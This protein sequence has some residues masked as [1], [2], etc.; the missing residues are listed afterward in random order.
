MEG[1][2]VLAV[3]TRVYPVGRGSFYDS[4]A[5][6]YMAFRT[7]KGKLE[8]NDKLFKVMLSSV[9]LEPK[10]RAYSNATIARFYKAEAQKEAMQDQIWA[11]LENKITETILGETANAERGSE[12]SA[13]GA[14]QNIRGVQTFRDPAT[15]GTMELSNL[16]DHAWL[17]GSNE[18]IMSNDPNFNPNTNLSGSWNQLQ[19]VRPAP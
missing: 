13:F 15:G 7:P 4:H 3:V 6:D 14:D 1:W 12:A 2:V 11:A 8:V 19:A 18:Y 9:Q 10:W 5:I 16:Y 17:N